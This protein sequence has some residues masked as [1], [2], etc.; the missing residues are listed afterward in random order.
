[1]QIFNYVHRLSRLCQ[2]LSI[3]LNNALFNALKADTQDLSGTLNTPFQYTSIIANHNSLKYI[4][5][6]DFYSNPINVNVHSIIGP[7]RGYVI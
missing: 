1:M 7:G 2:D 3:L 6:K 4:A 5:C